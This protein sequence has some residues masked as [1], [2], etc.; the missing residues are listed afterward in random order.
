[1]GLETPWEKAGKAR[2]VRQEERLDKIH[3]GQKGVNSGRH[4]RWKR[5]GRIGHFLVECRDTSARSFSI[6]YDEFHTITRQAHQTPPG[7]L[8][9]MQIDILDLSLFVMRLVDHEDRE[10]RL[11]M[12]EDDGA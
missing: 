8:P 5:D 12:M 10:I 11:G 9:A 4:W 2:H 6:G 7:L 3:G 1:V